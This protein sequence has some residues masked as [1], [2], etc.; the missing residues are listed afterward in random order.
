VPDTI[1]SG[2]SGEGAE[3]SDRLLITQ[4]PIFPPFKFQFSIC[5][6]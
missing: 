5:C 3:K 4:T 2:S 6:L 1:I